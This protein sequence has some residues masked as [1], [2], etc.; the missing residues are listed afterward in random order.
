M[1][2]WK[3]KSIESEEDLVNKPRVYEEIKIYIY[4]PNET[5]PATAIS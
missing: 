1:L 3:G 5:S 4:I 2:I